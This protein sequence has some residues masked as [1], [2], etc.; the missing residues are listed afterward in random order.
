MRH[1]VI[2][3]VY[4]YTIHIHIHINVLTAFYTF[5]YAFMS[6]SERPQWSILIF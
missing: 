6:L 5:S 1:D 3:A 4:K 2:C